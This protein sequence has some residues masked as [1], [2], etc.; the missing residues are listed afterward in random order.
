MSHPE[1]VSKLISKLENEYRFKNYKIKP[2]E[3]FGKFSE[4]GVHQRISE[5]TIDRDV[6]NALER[7]NDN[8]HSQVIFY[9]EG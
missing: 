7:F 6:S 4:A 3:L 2:S 8:G 9:I 5:R 1:L